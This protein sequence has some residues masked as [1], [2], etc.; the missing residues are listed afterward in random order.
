[1]S[2]CNVPSAREGLT[3]IL[4]DTKLT[5]SQGR[6]RNDPAL[7]R[8]LPLYNSAQAS[9]GTGVY[10]HIGEWGE[11]GLLGQ[12]N[13]RWPPQSINLEMCLQSRKGAN[14]VPMVD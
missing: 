1:M 8:N 14:L 2:H 10:K 5:K 12:Q 9:Q 4:S 13:N 11:G 3:H 7:F 6:T